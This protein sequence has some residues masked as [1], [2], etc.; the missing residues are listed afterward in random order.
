[1]AGW[2]VDTSA[3]SRRGHKD[4]ADELAKLAG[5]EGGLWVSPPVLLELLREPQ[6]GAVATE[7]HQLLG[8]LKLAP[9]DDRTFTL[10]ADAME[11]L[12]LHGAE[13][14]RL[15]LTDLVTA[16]V[17][18]QLKLGVAHCDGDYELLAE[19]SGLDFKHHKIK[20]P[21][22]KG[23]HPAARQRELRKQLAQTLHL[24]PPADAEA[25]L[26]KANKDA[27]KL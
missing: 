12:A 10:A 2:L 19:H 8:L 17:A 16:A 11:Q 27:D 13:A 24:K 22:P 3:W 14:H 4:V 23:Q 18:H 15:P 5:E 25:F 6:H 9:S 1:M 21:P 20:I 26:V 7:R